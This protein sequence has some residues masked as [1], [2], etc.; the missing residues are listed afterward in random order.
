MPVKPVM[1][2]GFPSAGFWDWT[3][4]QAE[5]RGDVDSRP[6]GPRAKAVLAVDLGA[7]DVFLAWA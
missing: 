2:G 1:S 6:L 5:R 3:V 4:G 7:A